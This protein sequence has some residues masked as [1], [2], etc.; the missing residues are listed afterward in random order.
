MATT[1]FPDIPFDRF[2]AGRALL[3]DGVHD[4]DHAALDERIARLR[5]ALALRSRPG[6]PVAIL[7]D[8]SPEWLAVDL[9]TQRAG[10]TLVPLPLFFTP[11]QWQHVIQASGAQ[12]LFCADPLQG[13]A[14]GFTELIDCGGPLVL[15]QR[16]AAASTAVAAELDG[17]QKITFTSGTTAAP[18]GV[19]LGS[20]QQ[21]EVARALHQGLGALGIERHLC[22]L[23]FAV[24]LEN[25]AGPYTALLSGATTICPPLAEVGLSGASGF[26][27]QR[28]LDAIARYQAG[29]VILLPQMLAALVAAAAPG[30]PR[31]ASLRFVAVGG[32]R[33][34]ARILATAR[35]RGIPVFEGY[36]L[37]E[38][39]S[40]VALNL[41][42]ALRD[43]SVGRPLAHRALR[44]AQDGEIEV[45]CPAAHYLG[46]PRAGGGWL[47][48]GDLGHLDQDG[49]LHIDGRKKD[50]LIT[51]YGRNVS[52][53]WPESALLGTGL[54]AQ[55]LV[56]G[57]GQPWLGALLVPARADLTAAQLQQAVDLANRELPDYAQVRRWAPAAPFTPANGLATANGRPRRP[58]IQQQYADRIATLFDQTEHAS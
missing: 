22:L 14:L 48:T 34:P 6:A 27:P 7:A 16:P 38:C 51:G 41:P 35:E 18:K 5:T 13:A 4:L 37:S 26:D 44:I 30:D 8:N 56:V 17:V 40:V 12:A 55:A 31:L 19:C 20:A 9:A 28:C 52:P 32:A 53:E 10:L 2:P 47:A 21:W 36:G 45:R 42:G 39:C 33:T 23:P 3:S 29:S 24:L 58:L 49:Y 15:C 57:E 1:S 54:V 43:G 46:Q 50:I 25:I 11:A